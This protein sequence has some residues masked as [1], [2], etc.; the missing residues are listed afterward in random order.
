MPPKAP[1]SP[2]AAPSATRRRLLTAGK[3]LL[4]GGLFWVLFELGLLEFEPLLYLADAWALV[5]VAALFAAIHWP[6]AAWRWHILLHVQGID[7]SFRDTF[8]VA[9]GAALIGLYL[10]GGVGF[11]VARIGFGLSLSKSRLSVLAL[12]VVADR[13]VGVMGLMVIGLAASAAYA[14][15]ATGEAA[16]AVAG[17]VAFIAAIFAAALGGM[18]VVALASGRLVAFAERRR[19]SES[20]RTFRFLEQ[21]VRAARLYLARPRTLVASVGLSILLHTLTLGGIVVVAYAMGLADVSWWKYALAGTM[22]L[23]ANSLPVTPGGVGIGEAAFSQFMLWL[24]PA[25]GALP[26]ATAF[27]AYRVITAATLVP[28]VAFMPTSFRRSPAQG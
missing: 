1:D 12:S 11:D 26:Y 22:S 21:A 25:A 17:M 6:I 24:E 10:P 20:N 16:G 13:L 2:G 5:L 4:A 7:P 8:R 3:L 18:T 19:W 14:A 23:V 15:F 28:A 27:L 9:Y